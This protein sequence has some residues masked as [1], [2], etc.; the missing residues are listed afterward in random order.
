M[1]SLFYGP[2]LATFVLA[3]VFK[4]VTARGANWGLLSGVAFNMYLW[5]AVPQVFWF[6][7]NLAGFLATILVA[8][9]AT[10]LFD[11]VMPK[12]ADG[13][14]LALPRRETA[15]LAAAFLVIMVVISSFDSVWTSIAATILT[16]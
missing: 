8:L 15:I 3:I 6:W 12:L 9:A 7:W 4:G 5:L 2:I 10:A 11:H 14:R 1:G 13:D 16:P